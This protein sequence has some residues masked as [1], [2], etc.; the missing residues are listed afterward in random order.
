MPTVS[1]DLRMKNR[2]HGVNFDDRDI[3]QKALPK[4]KVETAPQQNLEGVVKTLQKKSI[5]YNKKYYE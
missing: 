3:P 2:H 5:H 1:G 4:E